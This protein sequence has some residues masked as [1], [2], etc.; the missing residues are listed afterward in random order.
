MPMLMF[1]VLS[2]VEL[3]ELPV[4]KQEL[5]F[6]ENYQSCANWAIYEQDGPDDVK[7]MT[8]AHRLKA[9]GAT[10]LTERSFANSA[11]C[12]LYQNYFKDHHPAQGDAGL[13]NT[14]KLKFFFSQVVTARIKG[15]DMYPV[16]PEKL[17]KLDTT[18]W[19]QIREDGAI[20]KPPKLDE[21][22]FAFIKL[23]GACRS[24]KNCANRDGQ[25]TI[26]F[27]QR[28][29]TAS[30]GNSLRPRPSDRPMPRQ[31]AL[32]MRQHNAPYGR[33]TR[34]E[35]P[36]FQMP[37]HFGSRPEEP[38]GYATQRG[39]RLGRPRS[40]ISWDGR[41]SSSQDSPPALGGEPADRPAIEDVQPDP[42]D[43]GLSEEPKEKAKTPAAVPKKEAKTPAA[44][45]KKKAKTPAAVTKKKAK[46]PAAV[47][48][49]VAVKKAKAP[50]LLYVGL[51]SY[52]FFFR[53]T[54]QVPFDSPQ[55]IGTHWSSSV[56]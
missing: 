33:A 24:S 44:V 5:L 8:M 39:M 22:D 21:S 15:P 28:M 53:L 46:T 37:V 3:Q 12:A 50:I 56:R 36:M 20:V 38:L 6:P 42:A 14:R 48:K 32:L 41:D 40:E 23:G 55:T 26:T 7:L 34:E 16:D 17:E 35:A 27:A 51:Y 52:I 13:S 54:G 2:V 4:V 47:P 10:R 18:L 29:P 45:T 30:K 49:K 19:L 9:L 25:H 11:A 43:H 31:M 1:K